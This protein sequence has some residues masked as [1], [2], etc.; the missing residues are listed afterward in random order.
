MNNN[1]YKLRKERQLSQVAVQVATG[2]DQS[3]LSKYERGSRIPPTEAL[4]ILAEFYNVSIDY[5]M[6]RTENPD[7]NR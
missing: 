5:I 3:V 4:L 2:I 6:C 7:I 1:L